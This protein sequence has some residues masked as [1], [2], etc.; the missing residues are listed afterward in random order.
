MESRI[1]FAC[2][3]GELRKRPPFTI[4]LRN[5]PYETTR[6]MLDDWLAELGIT[7]DT[8][9]VALHPTRPGLCRGVAYVNFFTRETRDAAL[10]KLAGVR[11][12]GRPLNVAALDAT[13]DGGR[14]RA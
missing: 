8:A 10:V 14:G 3:A 6:P 2:T 13:S 4:R 12:L 1:P 5:I 7:P 9:H 11:W